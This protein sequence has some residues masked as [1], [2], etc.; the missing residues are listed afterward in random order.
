[1]SLQAARE[2]K[3]GGPNVAFVIGGSGFYSTSPRAAPPAWTPSRPRRL[4]LLGRGVSPHSAEMFSQLEDMMCITIA[5]SRSLTGREAH[6]T[7]AH[8][9]PVAPSTE[10][11]A[12]VT[13][14]SLSYCFPGAWYPSPPRNDVLWLRKGAAGKKPSRHQV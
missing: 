5:R 9:L 6:S 11:A 7:L 4:S 2:M 14:A 3:F 13:I 12:S 8:L 10:T 1:H